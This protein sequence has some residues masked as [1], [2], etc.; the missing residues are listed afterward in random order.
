MI[1]EVPLI[2]ISSEVVFRGFLVSFDRVSTIDQE[3]LPFSLSECFCSVIMHSILK[4]CRFL[5]KTHS[6]Q[7]MQQFSV[8][9]YFFNLG[10]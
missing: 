3:N 7:N 4:G 10:K 8:L 6:W 2:L 1:S 5:P 9:L